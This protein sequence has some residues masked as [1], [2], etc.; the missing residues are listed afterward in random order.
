MELS[1]FCGFSRPKGLNNIWTILDKS[2]AVVQR[3]VWAI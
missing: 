1:G 3:L 2:L